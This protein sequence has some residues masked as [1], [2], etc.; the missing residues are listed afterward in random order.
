MEA[1]GIRLK[2]ENEAHTKTIGTLNATV[3]ELTAQVSTLTS[4][5]ATQKAEL[6]KK[7]TGTLTTVIPDEKKEGNQ[8]ADQGA[9]VVNNYETSVD[10]EAR[11]IRE[12]NG[13][14]NTYK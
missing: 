1:E 11:Q 10:K 13:K 2:A 8:A 6:D 7:P 5:V 14:I 4:T 12:Q 3:T 9:A